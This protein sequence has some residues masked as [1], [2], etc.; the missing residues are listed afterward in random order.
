MK[1]SGMNHNQQS[2]PQ[3]NDWAV[4]LMMSGFQHALESMPYIVETM[5]HVNIGFRYIESRGIYAFLVLLSFPLLCGRYPL[6]P[7]WTFAG[8][9]FL[10]HLEQRLKAYQRMQNGDT[11]HSCYTGTPRLL[12]QFPWFSEVTF[13][14]YIEPIVVIGISVAVLPFDRPIAVFVFVSG[15]LLLIKNLREET[16]RRFE[17]IAMHDAWV[18]NQMTVERFRSMRGEE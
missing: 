13:K 1:V 12:D 14:I 9:A 8:I 17:T 18:E 7:Y 10:C 4:R 6:W 11:G 2:P 3:S 16:R 5:L 15:V